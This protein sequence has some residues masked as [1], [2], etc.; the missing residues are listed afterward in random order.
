MS[1]VVVGM[2]IG[3]LALLLKPPPAVIVEKRLTDYGAEQAAGTL[4]K[5]PGGPAATSAETQA[6]DAKKVDIVGK[7]A[8]FD[9]KPGPETGSWPRFRGKD[10]SN[11]VQ[12]PPVL[13]HW[14][15]G[16]PPA[17][18][19]TKVGQGYA[20]PVAH[21]GRVFLLDYDEKEGGD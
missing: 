4:P 15:E 20:G 1:L 18:W 11:S 21:R 17:V 6:P 2:A 3:F 5:E 8:T 14:P 19:R 12:G 7:L 13:E 9:G 10:F 16:G